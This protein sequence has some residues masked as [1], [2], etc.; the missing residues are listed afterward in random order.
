[1]ITVYATGLGNYEYSID[2]IH[3]Q[4]SNQFLALYSGEYTVH[5]RD[6]NGCGT[7]TEE[8]FLLMYPKFFT[9]NE[10]S[11]NDTWN[12]KFSDLETNLTVKI[13]DRYGKLIK[14]LIQNNDWNGTMNGHELPSDDYWFVATRTDGKEYKGHFS[15][16]R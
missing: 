7:S 11:F 3:Y 2:G 5:V 6:K 16:K 8:V 9:P 4:D 13:F 10:D 1:M 12:I 14:E 15:L